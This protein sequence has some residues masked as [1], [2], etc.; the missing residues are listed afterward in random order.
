M[1]KQSLRKKMEEKC[2][3]KEFL[4]FNNSYMTF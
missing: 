2:E 1:L 4:Q 3:K